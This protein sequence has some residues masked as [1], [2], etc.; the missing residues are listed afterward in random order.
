[1]MLFPATK[2]AAAIPFFPPLL[3]PTHISLFLYKVFVVYLVSVESMKIVLSAPFPLCLFGLPSLCT[4]MQFLLFLLPQNN[5]PDL[6]TLTTYTV[7][8]SFDLP[9]APS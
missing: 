6:S 7:H 9:P 8:S 2:S 4:K 5:L 1:M 3:G